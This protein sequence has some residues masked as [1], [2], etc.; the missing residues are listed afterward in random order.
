MYFITWLAGSSSVRW[1]L[2]DD[3]DVDVNGQAEDDEVPMTAT[4][5]HDRHL[6]YVRR[7]LLR[8]RQEEAAAAGQYY[9]CC[10]NITC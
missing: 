4:N 7:I 1:V 9:D 8:E 5:A 3:D 2:W 10:P 6:R